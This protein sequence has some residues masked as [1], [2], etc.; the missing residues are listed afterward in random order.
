MK[1]AKALFIEYKLRLY[2]DKIQR[3][4]R[5]QVNRNMISIKC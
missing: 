2:K 5:P 3:A 1:F 4:Q